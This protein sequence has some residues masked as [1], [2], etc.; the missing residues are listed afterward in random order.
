MK[1]QANALPLLHHLNASVMKATKVIHAQCLQ[2]RF[3]TSI[4]SVA[5]SSP[6]LVLSVYSTVAARGVNHCQQRDGCHANRNLLVDGIEIWMPVRSRFN[7]FFRM[8][9]FQIML[10]IAYAFKQMKYTLYLSF[11]RATRLRTGCWI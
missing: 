8:Q 6:F 2:T 11:N 3:G 10:Y 7:S 4:G 1:I 5:P 9:M